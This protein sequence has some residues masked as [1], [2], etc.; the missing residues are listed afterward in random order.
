[1]LWVLTHRYSVSGCILEVLKFLQEYLNDQ[2]NDRTI[3][4]AFSED[5]RA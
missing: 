5:G 4:K 2:D 3:L 1:M